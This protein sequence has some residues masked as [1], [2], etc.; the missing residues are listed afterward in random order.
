MGVMVG[1]AVGW[2]VVQ[3][4]ETLQAAT[5]SLIDHP[6]LGSPL[7]TPAPLE[8]M[9]SRKH[10]LTDG[11]PTRNSNPTHRNSAKHA[12][13]H[14][15]GALKLFSDAI[16]CAAVLAS[17]PDVG[18]ENCSS[19]SQLQGSSVK[20]CARVVGTVVGRDDAGDSVGAK[21]SVGESLGAAM[22]GARVHHGTPF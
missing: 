8:V 10:R 12:A 1:P 5:M 2:C 3:P 20:V 18:A 13:A 7:F 17:L 16:L 21:V 9:L 6:A 22:L 11:P 4:S 15:L 19:G 14:A